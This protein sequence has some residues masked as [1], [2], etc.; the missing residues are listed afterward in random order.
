[1]NLLRIFLLLTIFSLI[2]FNCNEDNPI[3]QDNSSEWIRVNNG[4]TDTS[5]ICLYGTDSKLYAG[6]STGA[7]L[8]TNC[9]E[10]WI[11]IGTDLPKTF[12]R[13]FTIVSQNLFAGTDSGV[14]IS[15]NDGLNWSA[16]KNGIPNSLIYSLTTKDNNLFAGTDFGVY[17]STNNGLNWSKSSNGIPDTYNITNFIVIDSIIFAGGY[18]GVYVSTNNGE[19]WTINNNG[20]IG[21]YLV[22]TGFCITKSTLFVGLYTNGIYFS[23]DYG[24][25]WGVSDS[26]LTNNDIISLA[27][28]GLNIYV[29]TGYGMFKSIDSGKSWTDFGLTEPSG[30]LH[31]G[32]LVIYGSHIFAGTSRGVWRR[33]LL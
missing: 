32:S 5:I 7:F 27:T 33:A 12:V 20:F 6:S 13:S 11:D 1:M 25:S 24:L 9:G 26:G 16:A 10:N 18:G 29:G 17:L 22:V 28:N 19:N 8:S 3:I 21:P 31:F 30:L 23:S 4:I 15:T 14:F 2:L